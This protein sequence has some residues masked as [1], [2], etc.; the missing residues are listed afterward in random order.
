[1]AISFS[2]P[3]GIDIIAWSLLAAA[4][5]FAVF[6]R[7]RLR[8]FPLERDE[9][10]FAYA[11]Q[12]LLHGVPPYK[13]AY[14]M[15]L[16]GTYIAYAGL[17]AVFGQTTTGIHLG[18]LAVNLAT[19]VLLYRLT[20][21]LFDPISAGMAA[22]VYSILSVSPALLGMA[23]HATH[24]VA[25]FALAGVC[26]LWRHLQ[27]GR[28][29]QAAAAGLMM[30][31]AFLMKQQGV[32]MSVFGGVML[33]WLGLRLAS[34][35]R[36]KLPLALASYTLAALLPYALI[37]L[38]L[39]RA[40][41]WKTFWFWTVEYASKYVANVPLSAAPNTF[42]YTFAYIVEWTWP[43]WVLALVGLFALFKRPSA[44]PGLRV[45]VVGLLVSSFAC[46][47][48]GFY[49]RNHYFIVF[50][51]GVAMLA[52]VGCRLLWDLAA[53]RFQTASAAD[54][55]PKRQRAGDPQ[56]SRQ[57]RAQT[58][59]PQPAQTKPATA[60]FGPFSSVVVMIIV[61]AV[62]GTV[63]MQKE[64]YFIWPPQDACHMTYLS[65]PFVEA[66]EIAEYLKKH[67]SA[68]D[69]I[70]VIG[71]EPE[72]YFDAQ[73]RSATGYI[74]T[75]GL[76]EEQP[77]AAKMQEEMIG[78]IA[79]AKPKYIVFAN[80]R[81]SWLTQPRSETRVID[82]A[83][84]YIN[85]N[86]EIVAAYDLGSDMN[87]KPYWEE[88]VRSFPKSSGGM[89]DSLWPGP[90]GIFTNV[91]KVPQVF[92]AISK[93]AQARHVTFADVLRTP[94]GMNAF[95]RDVDIGWK[96]TFFFGVPNTN[97]YCTLPYILVC[98]KK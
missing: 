57:K 50:L 17:M 14:N 11:G 51:P 10:E 87:S 42:Y 7:V 20:R 18:L 22:I 81:C 82:W 56:P 66:P 47:C 98:R 85:T 38:W 33:L 78:E 25:F 26:L 48:P 3:R 1:M 13:L 5:I 27:S 19:I 75:Y 15:K 23:A 34:Y 2:R 90:H 94:E 70:A 97:K 73:R 88:Q 93:Y 67:T 53:I 44:Q 24:F 55:G 84:D 59:S 9:G 30:G 52:G 49:F 45:F 39:W 68:N 46:V 40:G 31:L 61:A 80:V 83:L 8:E 69:K 29:W 60:G 36:K 71:S 89:L 63:W 43:L 6:V 96:L 64:F 41:V 72:I 35:P 92:D 54:A 95:Q 65:N 21:K 74:Y 86:Y 91:L 58:K 76:V 77:L 79:A 28:W 62:I 32:F 4:V 16:P 12:L 37:C